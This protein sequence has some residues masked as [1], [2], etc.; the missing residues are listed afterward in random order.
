MNDR[1]LHDSTSYVFKS[2]G[3]MT[4]LAISMDRE[5]DVVLKEEFVYIDTKHD[6][7]RGFSTVTLWTYHP[8]MCKLI[9]L[10]VMYVEEENSE[11]FNNVLENS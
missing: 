7:C 3:S 8:V 1:F 2:S 6:R 5:G 11:N 4:K 9:R 10:A